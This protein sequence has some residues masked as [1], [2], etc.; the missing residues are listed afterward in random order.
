MDTKVEGP[1]GVL[2]RVPEAATLLE[3]AEAVA[4]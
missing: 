2:E 3:A 4:G 1:I